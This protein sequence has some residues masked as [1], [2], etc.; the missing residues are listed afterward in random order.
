[1]R[2]PFHKQHEI[3]PSITAFDPSGPRRNQVSRKP[4]RCRAARHLVVILDRGS[5]WKISGKSHDTLPLLPLFLIALFFTRATRRGARRPAVGDSGSCCPR[6]TSVKQAAR[7]RRSRPDVH[8]RPG[9]RIRHA[10]G[11]PTGWAMSELEAPH[12]RAL[13]FLRILALAC[14]CSLDSC[15]LLPVSLHGEPVHGSTICYGGTTAPRRHL[16]PCATCKQTGS[17]VN[18]ERCPASFPVFCQ[19]SSHSRF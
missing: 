7:V 14:G 12:I 8:V 2:P 4:R 16:G 15:R 5:R 9:T 11:T 6:A 17:L 19:P 10:R 1:M 3:A 18:F 13:E